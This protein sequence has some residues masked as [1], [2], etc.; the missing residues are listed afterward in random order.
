MIHYISRRDPGVNRSDINTQ[1]EP[2]LCFWI[3]PKVTAHADAVSKHDRSTAHLI[4]A[5]AFD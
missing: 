1:C 2:P 3:S 4:Y 5:A